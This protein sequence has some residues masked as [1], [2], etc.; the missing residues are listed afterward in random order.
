MSHSAG[1]SQPQGASQALRQFHF[2]PGMVP[3]NIHAVLIPNVA[4]PGAEKKVNK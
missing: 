4:A 2:C 3:Q 1:S